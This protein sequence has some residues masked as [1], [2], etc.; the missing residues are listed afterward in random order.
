MQQPIA[1]LGIPLYK[2]FSTEHALLV[3]SGVRYQG[4][5]LS[6]DQAIGQSA[7]QSVTVPL[8]VNYSLSR[9]TSLSFIG[10]ATVGSDFNK[11][12]D[13]SDI[14]YTIGFRIGFRPGT[15]FKYGITLTYVKSYSGKFLLPLPD[16]DWTISKNWSL[17]GVVPARASL[18]YKLTPAQSLGATFGLSG[19]MYRL[20]TETQSQYLHLQQSSIGMI[21]DLKL[22]RRWLWTMVA[23]HT[24][25]QKLETFNLD[26]Q[27]P[28]DGF[29]KLNDRVSNISYRQNSFIFQGGLSYLF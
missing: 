15:N 9:T 14:Q 12:I 6:G 25:S 1:D 8:L 22:G 27:V 3:K 28:F 5:F 21:Y 23:G 10:L 20:N 13:G 24:L 18:K 26:Q 29:G 7:F 11:A 17:T 4:L 16:I 19:N 2:D